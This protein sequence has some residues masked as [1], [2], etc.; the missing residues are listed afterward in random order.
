MLSDNAAR[1]AFA[2]YTQRPLLS[3]TGDRAYIAVGDDAWA[4][5]A[6][7]FPGVLALQLR[8][9]H[10]KISPQLKHA[11]DKPSPPRLRLLSH[12]F[13]G[14]GCASAS[15]I[16]AAATTPCHVYSHYDSVELHCPAAAAAARSA[17]GLLAAAPGVHWLELKAN[18]TT[19]NR[20]GGC[21]IST[22]AA[23]AAP[24]AASTVLAAIALDAATSIIAVAGASLPQQCHSCHPT[25]SPCSCARPPAKSRRS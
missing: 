14:A 2:L 4:S 16:I 22:G 8:P 25:F 6:R 7:S 20:A 21:T 3:L 23:C 13:P 10:S 15:R 12:C 19:R 24:T 17:A 1:S 9:P 5:A 11:L 18:L